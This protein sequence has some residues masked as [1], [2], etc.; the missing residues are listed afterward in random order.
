MVLL[1]DIVKTFASMLKARN[2]DPHIYED[3]STLECEEDLHTYLE[4]EYN[5]IEDVKK[6]WNSLTKK[7]LLNK[8]KKGFSYESALTSF[9]NDI[10]FYFSTSLGVTLVSEEVERIR[11]SVEKLGAKG[12]IVVSLYDKMPNVKKTKDLRRI[13]FLNFTYLII[14]FE[15]TIYT[16]TE[17][18]IY[19]YE[20]W[21]KE[22]ERCEHLTLPILAHNDAQAIFYGAK[23]GQIVEC[24]RH[25]MIEGSMVDSNVGVRKVQILPDDEHSHPLSGLKYNEF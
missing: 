18:N 19:D 23:V 20:D 2:I 10:L 8:L 25:V 1:I 22:N 9:H 12:C 11:S 13:E 3:L 24:V 21:L 16:P 17:T 6:S 14:D 15:D 4:D 5:E 7:E